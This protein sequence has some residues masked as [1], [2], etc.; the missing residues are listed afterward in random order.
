[1]K[2][3]FTLLELMIT[4]AVLVILMGFV[5]R[6]VSVGNDTKAQTVTQMR[7]QCLKNCLSG[8][9]AAFGSYPPVKVHG[10]RDIYKQVDN[11]GIQKQDG[12]T[13]K[14][15]WN[16]NN[17][18]E[19][20][21]INAWNQIRA[22]CKA[23]PVD[24]RFPFPD[25]YSEKV[26][27]VSEE[28][29]ARVQDGTYEIKDEKRRAVLLA[30]FDDG[31]SRN[32]NRHDTDKMDWNEVQVFKFGLMSYLLPH[33]I[34]MMGNKD[35]DYGSYMQWT[36]NNTMPCNALTGKRFDKW[37]VVRDNGLEIDD[38]DGSLYASV[39]NIPSQAVCARWMPNL[40]GICTANRDITLFGV[41]IRDGEQGSELNIENTDIEIFAPSKGDA[42]STSGGYV[43]DGVTVKDGW[44]REFYYYSAEPYQSYQLWSAGPNGRTFPSWINRDDKKEFSSK[45]NECIGKWIADDIR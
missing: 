18:G 8:Y 44:G 36:G 23:Q 10:S 31:F 2:R 26:E 29:K 17:I 11:H 3:A 42:E 12:S 5:F 22:V 16:W 7:L 24:C 35:I 45:A 43:L 37:N 25:G 40:E 13:N 19:T 32:R 30:G 34:V 21:E 20:A 15:L 9:H 6:L 4:I 27:I 14:S 41:D 38:K 33:Y 39:A 1:M 28:I